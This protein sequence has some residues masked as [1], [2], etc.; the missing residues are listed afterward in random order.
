MERTRIWHGHVNPVRRD[1]HEQF[2]R[3]LNSDEARVQYAKFLLNGYMLAQ[4]D[5][6]LTISM[7][8]EEP[9]AIIRFLRNPRMW[10]EFWEYDSAGGSEDAPP[11]E[12]VR[13][14]WRRTPPS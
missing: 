7:A 9:P 14:N 2:V 5:D 13:V 11:A 6:L 3:W 8:A 10:P 4:Q 12:S 1:E